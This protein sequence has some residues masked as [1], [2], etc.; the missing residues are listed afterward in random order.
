LGFTCLNVAVLPFLPPQEEP[1]TFPDYFVGSLNY[2][3]DKLRLAYPDYDDSDITRLILEHANNLPLACDPDLVFVENYF[4]GHYLN[5]SH[6]SYR[7]VAEQVP[8]QKIGDYY[9]IFVFGGSTT[10]GFFE[11]DSKTIPSV[12]QAI[13]RQQAVPGHQPIA[14][15]NFGQ[16][17]YFSL[18]ERLF[19]QKLI[20]RGF[21]P[22]QAIFIDGLNDTHNIGVPRYACVNRDI[23]SG[24]LRC[25]RSGFCLPVT[26]LIQGFT[27]PKLS[28]EQPNLP[29]ADDQDFN[30][31]LIERWRDQ[32]SQ[33][34]ALAHA[35]NIPT[36]FVRQ[37]VPGFAYD[38]D[39][40]PFAVRSDVR[41]LRSAYT[42]PLWEETLGPTPDFPY[43]DLAYMAQDRQ[44]SLY[45]DLVH[46]NAI[47]MSDIAQEIAAKV[48]DMMDE[49]TRRSLGLPHIGEPILRFGDTWELMAW[50]SPTD[51]LQACQSATFDTWWQPYAL[52]TAADAHEAYLS[53]VLQNNQGVLLKREVLL[54][55]LSGS[56]DEQ[57][58]YPLAITLDIPCD[59]RPAAYDVALA[60]SICEQGEQI[61]CTQQDAFT[62]AGGLGA[63]PYLT[64]LSIPE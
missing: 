22:D 19:F 55:S 23:V 15:F 44:E 49:P 62:S 31:R 8:L 3:F 64:T 9:T 14:V 11:A 1:P 59:A 27:N 5:V 7:L 12:L 61:A 48:I 26:R 29:P 2:G 37:P 39:Y 25:P 24:L 60:M 46:Y 35:E 47:F 51:G 41:I 63:Y 40:H 17:S 30:A 42:Y 32:W 13:L 38:L 18:Q 6:D 20:Q 33:T 45:V 10:Y 56:P 4:K 53:V 58:L 34:Q 52:P 57:R 21:K 54:A 50:D 43:L 36:L 28:L 16:R